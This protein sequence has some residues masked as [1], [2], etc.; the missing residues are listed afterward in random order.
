MN[1]CFMKD[2]RLKNIIEVARLNR[3]HEALKLVWGSLF[4]SP[5]HEALEKGITVYDSGCGKSGVAS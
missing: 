2:I 3:Q 4:Y 5:V 1:E